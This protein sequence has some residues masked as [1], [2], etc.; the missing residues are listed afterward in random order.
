MGGGRSGG[1]EGRGGGGTATW[2]FCEKRTSWLL[3]FL[4]PLSAEQQGESGEDESERILFSHRMKSG[5]GCISASEAV[6]PALAG[7]D[8]ATLRRNEIKQWK[9]FSGGFHCFQ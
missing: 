3:C 1:A 5:P 7:A 2:V 6:A 8:V 9:Y 4:I